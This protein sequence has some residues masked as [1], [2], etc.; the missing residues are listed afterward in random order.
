MFYTLLYDRL[1]HVVPYTGVK[2]G[3][4][5]TEIYIHTSGRRYTSGRENFGVEVE[6]ESTLRLRLRLSTP[7]EGHL[8]LVF[9][10]GTGR[11]ER[12]RDLSG[13]EVQPHVS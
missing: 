3:I 1:Y 11:G 6:D 7:G 10:K 13:M 4:P 2:C 8:A 12:V 5:S 9:S